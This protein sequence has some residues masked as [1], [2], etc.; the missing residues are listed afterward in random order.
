MLPVILMR[1]YVG[2][3]LWFWISLMNPHK[4]TWGFA[5]DVPFAEYVAIATLLSLL[6]K[7]QVRSIPW[8][9]S[10]VLMFVLFLFTTLSSLFAWSPEVAWGEWEKFFKVLLFTFL[11]TMLVSGQERVRVLLLVLALSVA[12]YGAKG[13]FFSILTGG[14]HRVWGPPGRALLS[15]N[16][17]LGLAMVMV[18]PLILELAKDLEAKW[19]RNAFYTIAG[20]TAIAALF[21][22]S[23]GALLGLFAV[24][25]VY[26]IRSKQKPLLLGLFVPVVIVAAIVFVPQ[27]L[28]DRAETIETF[29]QDSSAMQRI[30]AWQVAIA[31]AL[32]SPITGAG[33]EFQ[34]GNEVRW[35]GYLP[36][37]ENLSRL[38]G[39]AHVAHSAYFQVL[40]QHGFLAFGVFLAMLVAAFRHA[41]YLRSQCSRDS[42]A[43][44]IGRYATGIQVGLVGY[45][46][47]GAFINV[48]YFDLLYAY[49]AAIAILHREYRQQCLKLSQLKGSVS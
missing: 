33:F 29:R 46:V 3:Y 18:I 39:S 37:D 36:D 1:P 40:G 38:G 32:E 27:Q 22:Y 7:R 15:S 41:G 44:W 11:T 43:P 48:A 45:M 20:L 14:Q 9:A 2:I 16:N 31:V 23:R 28:F 8:D 6:N 42:D 4:L 21:T 47:S 5:Y 10:L 35:F 17:F 12:F 34:D 19:L 30:R 26:V 25:A 13:G 49:I 24:A